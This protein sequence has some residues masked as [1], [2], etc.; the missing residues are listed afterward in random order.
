M[1]SLI[2]GA[3]FSSLVIK[4]LILVCKSADGRTR[5]GLYSLIGVFFFFLF[6]STA[7]QMWCVDCI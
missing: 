1:A 5:E 3:I 6:V 2:V 4:R 7:D